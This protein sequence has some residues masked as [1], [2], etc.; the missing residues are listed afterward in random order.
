MGFLLQ[1]CENVTQLACV[2]WLL[3]VPAHSCRNQCAAVSDVSAH[4]HYAKQRPFLAVHESKMSNTWCAKG[5]KSSCDSDPHPTQG[6]GQHAAEKPCQ[7]H[8]AAGP[9]QP[10]PMV[11]DYI[12]CLPSYEGGT[13]FLMGGLRALELCQPG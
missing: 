8:I 11:Q 6:R 9:Q 4:Q 10:G 2:I 5:C 12:R 7:Q 1:F 13:C 3:H